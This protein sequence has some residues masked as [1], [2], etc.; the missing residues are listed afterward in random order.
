VNLQAQEEYIHPVH[1]DNEPPVSLTHV[2]FADILA[3]S[4]P[5]KRIDVQCRGEGRGR[6]Y[7]KLLIFYI[8]EKQGA[9]R[10]NHREH[11]VLTLSAF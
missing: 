3:R 1:H 7:P 2:F 4:N 5:L 10:C 6:K 9:Q 11:R 8:I